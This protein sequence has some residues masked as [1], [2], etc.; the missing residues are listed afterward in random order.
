L[1]ELTIELEADKEIWLSDAD[2]CL[3]QGKLF[4]ARTILKHAVKV[5][6]AKRLWL[7]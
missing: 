5:K 4:S 1:I 2:I 3:K 7:K 6:D